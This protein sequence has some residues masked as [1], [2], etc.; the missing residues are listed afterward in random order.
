M[1]WLALAAGPIVLAA[2]STPGRPLYGEDALV[3]CAEWAEQPPTMDHIYAGCME[4]DNV[5]ERASYKSCDDGRTLFWTRVNWGW[6]GEAAQGRYDVNE[7][8]PASALAE[9]E[10]A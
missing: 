5:Y 1:R 6:L 7:D 8:P 3:R 2:C 4:P 9:C 10:G